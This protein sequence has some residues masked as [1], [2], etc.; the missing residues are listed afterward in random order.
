ME[1]SNKQR[2][3]LPSQ[4]LEGTK[5]E[6]EDFQNRVLRPLIKMQSNL[7]MHHLDAKLKTLSID[8]DQLTA[9]KQTHLL[10]TLF[11]KDLSFKREIIGMIIGHFTLEE[12][13][14]YHH[15]NKEYNRRIVQIVLNRSIDLRVAES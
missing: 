12:Y 10:T 9:P 2:P 3:I 14:I 8:F 13:A 7:L 5:T 1:E 6:A 11:S 15:Q 4:I